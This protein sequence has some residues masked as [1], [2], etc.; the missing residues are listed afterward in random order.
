[1]LVGIMF[2]FCIFPASIVG[3]FLFDTHYTPQIG[4]IGKSKKDVPLFFDVQ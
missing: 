1:M 3:S 4:D 2:H